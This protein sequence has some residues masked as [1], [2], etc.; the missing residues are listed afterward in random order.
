M[1]P[2][3]YL[4]KR[5]S[6]SEYAAYR[7][8]SKEIKPT[9]FSDQNGLR[10]FTA[11]KKKDKD[12]KIPVFKEFLRSLPNALKP[13]GFIDCVKLPFSA[14]GT[15]DVNDRHQKLRAF[16][17]DSIKFCFLTEG[18]VTFH[19]ETKE[20][21]YK[22]VVWRDDV[23]FPIDSSEFTYSKN[24]FFE[25]TVQEVIKELFAQCPEVEK[26][27]LNEKPPKV[28]LSGNCTVSKVG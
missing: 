7:D 19:I 12:T 24:L 5:I 9:I 26:I 22:K 1:P 20:K 17:S 11:C 28:N 3:N 14:T 18:Q 6:N 2:T 16:K 25:E 10:K 4:E 23:F 15:Q 8:F 13:Y 27:H 21:I